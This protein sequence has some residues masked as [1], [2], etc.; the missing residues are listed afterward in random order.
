M[1][2]MEQTAESNKRQTANEAVK[3]RND[4]ARF[5]L[6]VCFK[7]YLL[8]NV[9]LRTTAP[10]RA[11]VRALWREVAAAISDEAAERRSRE[12][13]FLVRGATGELAGFSEAALVR[14]KGGRRF[15]AYTM[16]LRE[17][18]RVP[19]LMLTVLNATRDFL[20]RFNHPVSPPEGMVIVTENPKLMRPGVRKLLA[21]HGYEYW[22]RTAWDE[23]VWAVEFKPRS[24][25]AYPSSG[26]DQKQEERSQTCTQTK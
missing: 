7:G 9:Y 10:Q 20:C 17:T 18:D 24:F 14:V 16:L 25:G 26:I 5:G 13:V 3:V 19:Y 8:E 11:E 2:H 23:D 1:T 12:V 6:G 15:Y 21:R 4:E 22:G